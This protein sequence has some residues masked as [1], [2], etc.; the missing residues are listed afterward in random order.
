MTRIP[1][2]VAPVRRGPGQESVW[3]Y[4][5]PPRVEPSPALVVVRFGGSVVASTQAA[6]RVLETSH[7]PAWYLP[8]G[9]FPEGALRPAEGSSWCE[10]KGRASYL[11]VVGGDGRIAPAAAWT[12]PQ[13]SPGYEGI[14]GYVSLYPAPMDE[15][16]VDGIVV[17]AQPGGFYGGWITPDVVGPFKGGPGTSGW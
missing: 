2:G 6:L 15:V 17:R 14:A 1:R 8:P 5:R 13:P 11:D 4:P 9:A 10:F 3:D 7:P 12:Y 16:T